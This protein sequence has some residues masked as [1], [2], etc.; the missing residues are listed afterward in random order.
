[1]GRPFWT[2]RHEPSVVR[3]YRST[4]LT[5]VA[6]MCGIARF[7]PVSSH[8]TETVR[9]PVWN[10][11]QSPA[12]CLPS[13]QTPSGTLPFACAGSLSYGDSVSVHP[14]PSISNSVASCHTISPA[15][16]QC[17]IERFAMAD[18]LITAAIS[19]RCSP[20]TSNIDVS[21]VARSK[22]VMLE[23]ACGSRS[24]TRVRRP[25]ARSQ[26][27]TRSIRRKTRRTNPR[28]RRRCPC[29]ANGG[30]SSSSKR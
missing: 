27:S 13:P 5:P 21:T 20:S 14:R 4:P 1:M 16:L 6:G 15:A 12:E 29:R 24:T 26:P 3:R 19:M 17:A 23:L 11:T 2:N 25:T 30:R 28:R 8:R 18:G 7:S 9:A 22:K 10:R